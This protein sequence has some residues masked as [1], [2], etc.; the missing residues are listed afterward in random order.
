[1]VASVMWL[2]CEFIVLQEAPGDGLFSVGSPVSYAYHTVRLGCGFVF[3]FLGSSSSAD[4]D[5]SL[6]LQASDPELHNDVAATG[7]AVRPV[8][9]VIQLRVDLFDVLLL[10]PFQNYDAVSPGWD[11]V[12]SFKLTALLHQSSVWQGVELTIQLGTM[13]TRT[14]L[15]LMYNFYSFQGSSCKGFNVIFT[16]YQ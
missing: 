2:P 14:S 5:R 6:K 11:S 13:K 8:R 9:S 1:M 16:L 3:P 15:W 7:R 10:V 12:S 4:F